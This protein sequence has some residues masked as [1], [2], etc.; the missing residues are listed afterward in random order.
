MAT[1]GP[2]IQ[3]R[4]R[5]GIEAARRGDRVNARRLLQ[6][7][8]IIDRDNEAALMWMA[9]VVESMDERRAFLERA[10]R[11]NPDNT[12]AR[13]ALQR[14]GVN[15]PGGRTG[16]TAA[17]P[18]PRTGG[19]AARAGGGVN[20]Y[21]IAAAVVAI[22]TVGV[23]AAAL[24]SSQPPTPQVTSQQVAQLTLN[25]V[26]ATPI[27]AEPDVPQSPPTA[28]PFIG[29]IVTLNPDQVVLPPTFTPTDTPE[30]TATFTP[31]ATFIPPRTY[32]IV[33]SAFDDGSALPGLYRSRA[34]G[35]TMQTLGNPADGF[36]DVAFSP[37]GERVA[38]T[39]PIE[40]NG[41]T[42]PQLFVMSL[43]NPADAAP[44]TVMT[45]PTLIQPAWSPD[46]RV[47]VFVSAEDGDDDLWIIDSD[48]NNLRQLTANNTT[49]RAPAFSPDGTKLVYASDQDSPGFS[50]IYELD[51]QT[52]AVTRLSDEAG[53]NYDPV[54]APDGERIA[55]IST[56]GGDGDVYIMDA[57][58]QRKFLLS[59]DDGGAEDRAPRFTPDGAYL[60]YLSNRDGAFVPYL[61]NMRTNETEPM[62]ASD[63]NWQS[64]SFNPLM[65]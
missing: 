11:V 6:Q 53:S 14:M 43:A 4:L 13:E 47:I 32:N 5:E 3:E 25:A 58:G 28:T 37:D 46:G 33:Y 41:V 22:L 17:A 39:R 61:L 7:V 34:D 48:G 42:A 30:P 63:Q 55:F 57:D 45:S 18:L 64:L 35:T 1:R 27:G 65:R 38:F 31:T 24:I 49:D 52:N 44:I 21:L 51:L 26:L 12:R 10:L 9:S 16:G 40:Q 29:V 15:V 62:F 20:S 19:T 2:D 54:Y 59:I 56:Q 36:T 23:V 8:L 60:A 50:E